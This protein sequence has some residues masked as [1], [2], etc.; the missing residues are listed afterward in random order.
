M[1]TALSALLPVFL[2]IAAGFALRHTVL[3]EEAQW[4]GIAR[5][6]FFVLF[7]ALIVGSLA[8]ADLA[9]VPVL[10]VGA[11]CSSQS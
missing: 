7:P 9:R 1:S 6:T 8:R 4:H 10:A 3:R 11:R 2:L 5:L